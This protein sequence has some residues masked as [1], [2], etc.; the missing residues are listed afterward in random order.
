MTD[1]RRTVLWVVFT[2]S[3]I[4][5]WDGWQKFNGH[6]SMFAPTIAKQQTAPSPAASAPVATAM[7]AGASAPAAAASDAAPVVA[8][9][10]LVQIKTDVLDV[11]LS[12]QGGTVTRVELPKYLNNPEPALQ[13][14]LLEAVG[15]KKKDVIAHP[16]IVLMDPLRGYTAETGLLLLGGA[17]GL[18]LIHI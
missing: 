18:S 6:P 1:I 10:Q 8:P 5:L 9:I 17:Q 2:M 3:L 12:T 15:L 7:A 14:P 13:D 16:P 4:F 11:T